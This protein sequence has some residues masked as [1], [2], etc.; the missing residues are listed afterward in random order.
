[1]RG[2]ISLPETLDDVDDDAWGAVI[3]AA[4]SKAHRMFG[5]DFG[6]T[7][8]EIDDDEIVLLALNSDDR[9]G[10]EWGDV[11]AIY[12]VIDPKALA[13]RTWKRLRVVPTA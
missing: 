11:G 2:A 13:K 7:E 10:M 12:F 5:H 9:A 8:G 1:L 3:E 6:D 4:R